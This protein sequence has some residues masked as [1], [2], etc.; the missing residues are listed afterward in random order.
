[1]SDCGEV[2]AKD[3]KRREF[4]LNGN[5]AAVLLKISSPLI[6]LNFF[7]YIYGIIDMVVVAGK[8][9]S[10]LSAVAMANQ[11]QNLFTTLGGGLS[12]GGAIMVS[13]FI[14]RGD[15]NLAKRSA[16]TFLTVA[17]ALSALF[18]GAIL[19]FTEPLLRAAQFS[20]SLLEAGRSYFA[21][22]VITAGVGIFNSSFLGF[23][24]S[25]GAT[26]NVLFIN[27][28]VMAAKITLTLV[29]VKG[30]GLPIVYIALSTLAA[31]LIIT[32]YAAVN[33]IRRRYLFA[34]SVRNNCFRKRIILPYLSLSTPVFLGKFVFSMGKVI[35]NAL[36]RQYGDNAPGALGVS[37]NV[38]GAVTNITSSTEEAISTVVSQNV[39]AGNVPRALKTFWVALAMDLTIALAGTLVLVF[40]SDWLSGFFSD[41]EG[42][43]AEEIAAQKSLIK[44]ILRY[45]MAGIP[46]LGVNAACMGFIYGLGYTKLSLVFNLSRLFVLRLPVVLVMVYCF[47]GFG[48]AGL[49]LG[50]LISNVGVGAVSFIIAFICLFKVRKKGLDDKIK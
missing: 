35:V 49:G 23:E 27:L 1:M 47:P 3:L 5:L 19:P 21:V 8:G 34:Y 20:D 44:S 6:V 38:S 11:L 32:F 41:G 25:R 24:K 14:G 12:T 13:R 40:I 39:G 15:Y 30:Y 43:A 16:T 33:L 37:N 28:A 17:A 36:G 45:E 2:A 10:V 50:M 18:V 46:M 4:I 22:Q 48:P 9:G 42:L 7:T 29:F 26:N 31:N